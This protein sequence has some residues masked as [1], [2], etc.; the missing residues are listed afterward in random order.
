MAVDKKRGL[1]L[2]LSSPSGAGKTTISKQLLAQRDNLHLSLSATTR[3]VRP[4]EIDGKDYSFL[5]EDAFKKLVADKALLEYAY[6][7]QH[8]Y[9]TPRAPVEKALA[10]GHDVLFDMDWQGAQQLKLNARRDLVSVFILPPSMAELHRRLI[11]RNQDSMDTIDFRMQ[12]A[13]AEISHWGEYDYVIVNHNVE[14]SVANIDAIL[15]AEKLRR[16][17]QPEMTDIVRELHLE[18]EHQQK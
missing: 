1:M 3:A 4:G 14:D 17:R 7:F 5:T 16:N 18:A 10:M 12:R 11:K 13:L 15:R 2:V 8:Y 9:G 6:V